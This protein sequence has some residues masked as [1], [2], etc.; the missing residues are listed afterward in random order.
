M[1]TEQ[2]EHRLEAA[3]PEAAPSDAGQPP[4]AQ[5]RRTNTF[6]IASLASAFFIGLAGLILGILALSQIKRTGQRGRGL[7]V[8][9]IVVGAAQLA[10]GMVIGLLV[11][12]GITV[13]A[14][15]AT[16]AVPFGRSS[17]DC[18]RLLQDVREGF[19]AFQAA[20]SKLTD[21]PQ[22]ALDEVSRFAD[23][24]QRSADAM[25]DPEV[26][27]AAKG[28]LDEVRDTESFAEL[29][30]QHPEADDVNVDFRMLQHFEDVVGALGE[31]QSVCVTGR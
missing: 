30:V 26:T 20:T 16:N 21:D 19:P 25:S 17:T 10:V 23:R 1:S 3:G 31:V 22:S 12:V 6:A 4:L 15:T 24:L 13:A 27:E 28:L 29:V 18:A 7:A 5:P 8:A 11:V 9:G 14:S 2:T